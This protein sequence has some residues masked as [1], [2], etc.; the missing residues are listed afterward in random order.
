[1]PHYY[2][3]NRYEVIES[4]EVHDVADKDEAE[5]VAD[6]YAALDWCPRPYT[7]EVSERVAYLLAHVIQTVGPDDNSD[8]IECRVIETDADGT[9]LEDI[10]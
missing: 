5:T 2:V 9:W 3:E 10:A 7:R 1:M 8:F 4:F 6:E